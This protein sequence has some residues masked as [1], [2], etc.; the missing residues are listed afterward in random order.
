MR[1]IGA[2]PVED[3]HEVVDD[4]F[5]AGGAKTLERELVV[6]DVAREVAGAGLDRF[7]NGDRF[8]DAPGQTG[9]GDLV[10]ARGDELGGPRF[11]VRNLVQ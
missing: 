5:D 2:H 6:F 4:D 11:T 1:E 8:D 3:G 10:T 9:G 7:G